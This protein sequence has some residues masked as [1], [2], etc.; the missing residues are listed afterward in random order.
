MPFSPGAEVALSSLDWMGREADFSTFDVVDLDELNDI[1][2]EM[3]AIETMEACRHAIQTPDR[4]DGCVCASNQA[5]YIPS[6]KCRSAAEKV[7][8]GSTQDAPCLRLRDH[9]QQLSS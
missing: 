9:T 3:N 1:A 8:P 2:A 7:V 4:N 6:T 5:A